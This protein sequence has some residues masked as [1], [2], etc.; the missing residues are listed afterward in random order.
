M[1]ICTVLGES[2]WINKRYACSFHVENHA[3]SIQFALVSHLL[4]V[5]CE[6]YMS[7]PSGAIESQVRDIENLPGSPFFL[8]LELSLAGFAFI[9]FA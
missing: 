2:V 6:D 4:L 1:E 8:S 9:S 5:H 7:H 3:G